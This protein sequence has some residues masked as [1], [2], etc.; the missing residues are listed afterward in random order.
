MRGR[1]RCGFKYADAHLC[2]LLCSFSIELSFCQD[3]LNGACLELF[4]VPSEGTLLTLSQF[5]FLEGQKM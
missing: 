2:L 1:G 3:D 4:G 5:Q